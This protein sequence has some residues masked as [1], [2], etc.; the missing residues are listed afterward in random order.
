MTRKGVGMGIGVGKSLVLAVL[1]ATVTRPFVLGVLINSDSDQNLDDEDRQYER[2][3]L[4]IPSAVSARSSLHFLTRESHMA[5]TRGDRIL[6]EFIATEMVHSGIPSAEIFDLN[7]TLN[8]PD[9]D[10]GPPSLKLV[11][12]QN[13]YHHGHHRTVKKTIFEAGLT[14]DV[15]K[16][17]D[18]SGQTVWREFPFHGYSPS[19]TIHG[20]DRI[21]IVYANYGRPS[22]FHTLVQNGVSIKDRAVL[23]RYGK[24]FRGLKVKNAQRLGAKAVIIYSDPADDGFVLGKMYPE[25]PWRPPSGI[26]RGSVQFNSKCA[27]DPF[28][29]DS[30]YNGTTVK[31]LCGVESSTDLIPSIP[32]IP[33]SYRDALPILEDLSGPIASNVDPSFAGGLT[34]STLYR[35]GPSRSYIELRVNNQFVNAS[36]PNVIGFIPGTDPPG[37]DMPVLVGNH[38]DAWVFGAADP[39]SGTAV[40]LEV[41]KG[42][43]Y[44]YR[45]QGWRPKRSIYFLSWSGEE[46]GLLGSTGWGEL[47]GHTSAIQR[48]LVYLNSDTTVSGDRLRASASPSLIPLWKDVLNDLENESILQFANPPYGDIIDANTDTMVTSGKEFE[49]TPSANK[50]GILGSGSDYTVFLDHFGIPSLDFAFSKQRASYG[51]YHSIYD[52]FHWMEKFGGRD[53]EPQSAFDLMVDAAKIWGFLVMR[54][55]TT[56]LVPLDQTSQGNSLLN[57][58]KRIS[59]QLW[60]EGNSCSLN[61]TEL[62]E[63]VSLYQKCAANVHTHCSSFADDPLLDEC[64]EKIG[65]V[66]RSFLLDAGLPGRSWFRHCL[67]APG[68][69]L[70]YAAEAFPGIQQALDVQDCTLAQEQVGVTAQ[71]IRDAATELNFSM[72]IETS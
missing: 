61:T 33:I 66:E 29:I 54:L 70:G 27:G 24:C 65:L 36:I 9:L 8:Y 25:G 12:F 5:G 45:H 55:A 26:Q 42:L 11:S 46:Y 59:D 7:V 44:L 64:N 4:Q 20:E 41:V 58:L 72:V 67:Q 71:A 13:E 43:G 52:S 28:R 56:K 31:S 35:F 53:G 57:Y 16:E 18:T 62:A 15:V 21:Q 68:I 40:L 32:S 17:D 60:E 69:D 1:V 38:R 51:Q 6:A 47:H 37:K 39:N 19:G 50:T 30:R 34:N 48:A 10:K 22:D 2:Q 14:E 63:A 23:V 3:Y 49:N